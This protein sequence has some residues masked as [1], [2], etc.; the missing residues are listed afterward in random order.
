MPLIENHKVGILPL[1][2]RPGD[3]ALKMN[4]QAK[5]GAGWSRW[6]SKSIISNAISAFTTIN[7]E[8]VHGGLAVG[9]GRLVEV[10]GGLTADNINGTRLF[11]NIYLTDI[12]RDVAS[13]SFDVWRC[14]DTELANEVARQAYPFV[15]QGTLKGWG[16]NLRDAASSVGWKTAGQVLGHGS[17]GAT[18]GKPAP[19]PA[20]ENPDA[21]DIA[22]SERRR[23]FCTQFVVW[24]YNVVSSR[25][26]HRGR[27]AILMDHKEAY[28]GYLAEVL[29]KRSS[30]FVYLG[31]IRSAHQAGDIKK[32]F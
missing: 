22:I 7:P 16:Y 27:G 26:L 11:A 21:L 12:A 18:S 25:I 5:L 6:G 30:N 2:L 20:R 23:F 13:A 17:L 32:L 28:P 31:C 9:Q 3:I 19:A 8:Y 10:N 14:K 4:Q 15:Y 1:N 24:L 29:H